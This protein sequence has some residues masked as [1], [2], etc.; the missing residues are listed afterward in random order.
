M[1]YKERIGIIKNLP[2]RKGK[3]Y[4][5]LNFQERAKLFKESVERSMKKYNVKLTAGYINSMDDSENLIIEEIRNDEVIN[6]VY[7]DTLRKEL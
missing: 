6:E 2:D 4:K 5:N 7:F 1:S 3:N